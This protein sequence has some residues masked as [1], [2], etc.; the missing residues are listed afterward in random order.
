MKFIDFYGKNLIIPTVDVK[1]LDQEVLS[2]QR[3]AFYHSVGI[4]ELNFENKTILELGPGTGYNAF[5]LLNNKIKRIVLV[6]LNDESIR[7]CKKNLKFFKKK[8]T[9][10]KEDI[11]KFK[12]RKKFDYVII[13]NVLANLDNPE[14]IL[15]KVDSFLK[16]KGHLIL[17]TSDNFS[18][19]A[20]KLRGLLSKIIIDANSKFINKLENKPHA[21][22]NVKENLLHYFFSSHFHKLGQNTRPK[23]KWIQDNLLHVDTWINKK[24]LSLDR[25]IKS[26][27]KKRNNFVYWHSSPA[28]NTSFTWYKKRNVKVINKNAVKNY[29][30]SQ[31]NFLDIR[32]NYI[33]PNDLLVNKIKEK[34]LDLSSLIFIFGKS[35]KNNKKILREII[36]NLKILNKNFSQIKKNNLIIKSIKSLITFLEY[37]VNYNW[38]NKKSLKNFESFWGNGTLQF[39]FLK[40]KK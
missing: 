32:E 18:L 6:D 16:E 12:T 19:F 17:T 13:E 37:Y 28:F 35:K 4:N 20:D 38:I 23:G 21:K 31:L 9:I 7:I 24:Y 1:D 15:A 39:S 40:H 10:I 30:N 27:N 29:F 22:L 34:I 25:I 8:C 3:T 5:Y 33:M 11:Y 36:K 26:I 2:K 14:K